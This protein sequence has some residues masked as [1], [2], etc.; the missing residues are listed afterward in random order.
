MWAKITINLA[1]QRLSAPIEIRDFQTRNLPRREA[2][3]TRRLRHRVEIGSGMAKVMD[4]VKVMDQT[5]C[6]YKSEVGPVRGN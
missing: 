4:M 1:D 3:P 2:S 5:S 6:K